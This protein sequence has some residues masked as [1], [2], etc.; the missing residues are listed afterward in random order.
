[1]AV[2]LV[3]VYMCRRTQ[4]FRGVNRLCWPADSN[5]PWGYTG[6]VQKYPMVH[7]VYHA[8]LVTSSTD[9]EDYTMLASLSRQRILCKQT[10]VPADVC[11][12]AGL[13]VV[14]SL[15]ICGCVPGGAADVVLAD[16]AGQ[17][18]GL[19]ATVVVINDDISAQLTGSLGT[20]SSDMTFS[21]QPAGTATSAASFEVWLEEL[22]DPWALT[23]VLLDDN[24]Q[25]I[26]TVTVSSFSPADLV[27]DISSIASV[28]LD[29][30]AQ[31]SGMPQTLEAVM[32][33][34]D[35][36]DA[37]LASRTFDGSF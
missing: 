35:S 29:F 15:F 9:A 36:N 16:S 33:L 11:V 2:P 10:I 1:M 37:T 25:V 8:Q 21:L 24:D 13:F 14:S 18:V 6:I 31:L 27:E 12:I 3:V 5:L 28:R 19:Q 26:D 30:N 20:L 32:V 4:P 7:K 22:D 17:H 34:L 23:A